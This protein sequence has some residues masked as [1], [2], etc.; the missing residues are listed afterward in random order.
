MALHALPAPEQ[1]APVRHRLRNA[2]R[3]RRVGEGHLVERGERVRDRVELLLVELEGRHAQVEPG[4]DVVARVVQ[5][6]VQPVGVHARALADLRDRVVEHGRRERL[7]LQHV[8]ARLLEVR[9]DH[10]A[11]AAA[12]HAQLVAAAAVVVADEAQA[13]LG[14]ALVRRQDLLRGRR[15]LLLRERHDRR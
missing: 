4:A 7:R 8:A 1:V 11:D 15:H 2:G 9:L 5:E 13:L 10:L 3:L 6:T 12:A 14:V